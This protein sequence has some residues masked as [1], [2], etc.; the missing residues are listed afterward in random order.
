MTA[1]RSDGKTV[2]AVNLFRIDYSSNETLRFLSPAYYGLGTH[3]DRRGS[4][5][6]LGDGCPPT[7]H[8]EKRIWKGYAAAEVYVEKAGLW[9]PVVFEMTE[10]L[11]LDLRG[12]YAR[13]QVWLLT[14]GPR[15]KDHPAPVAG[16][17]L[18]P[19]PGVEARPE[20][21]IWPVLQR[22]YHSREFP[23]SI[24]NP[25]PPKQQLEATNGYHPPN[26]KIDA[27]QNP[28]ERAKANQIWEEFRRRSGK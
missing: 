19:L 25:L 10:N 21:S 28:E 16:R 1:P 23:E 4:V 11:E 20:F 12:I 27:S 18:D 13:G 14:R 24:D 6:C 17:L 26:A 22:I 5:L 9:Y 8:R 15:R 7:L 2:V 3:Y